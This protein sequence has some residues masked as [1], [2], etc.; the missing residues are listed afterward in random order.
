M[1]LYSH[2]CLNSVTF[3]CMD[4]ASALKCNGYKRESLQAEHLGKGSIYWKWS[5][6]CECMGQCTLG[7]SVQCGGVKTGGGHFLN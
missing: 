2:N 6:V 1:C 7:G 3:W 5:L 4:S